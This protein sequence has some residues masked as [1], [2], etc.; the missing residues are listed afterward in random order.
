MSSS[1]TTR[2]GLGPSLGRMNITFILI[3][4]CLSKK[5]YI[6]HLM[7]SYFSIKL[8]LSFALV[9][10]WLHQVNGEPAACVG[11]YHHH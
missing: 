9:F 4:M 2:L 5:A 7:F 3:H 8:S 1:L 11:I 6:E 10:V